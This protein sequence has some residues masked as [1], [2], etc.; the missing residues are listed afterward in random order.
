MAVCQSCKVKF[1]TTLEVK[2]YVCKYCIAASE[3]DDDI[4]DELEALLNPSGRTKVQIEEEL[5]NC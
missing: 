3:L 2:S 1:T 5:N 4:D